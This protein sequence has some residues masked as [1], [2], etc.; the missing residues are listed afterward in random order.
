MPATKSSVQGSAHQIP[1]IPHTI[2]KRNANGSIM[3][4]TR[5][6]E[7]IFAGSGRA[8]DVKYAQDTILNPA[9]GQDRKYSRNPSTAMFCSV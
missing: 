4:N 3:T 5:R 8:A 7:M 6:M 9:N 2:E 1:V